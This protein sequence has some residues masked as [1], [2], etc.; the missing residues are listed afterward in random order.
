[1]AR[2][3]APGRGT[4][5]AEVAILELAPA[6]WRATNSPGRE[7]LRMHPMLTIASSIWLVPQTA[8]DAP[9]RAFA[10]RSALTGRR[11]SGRSGL[12]AF[13]SPGRVRIGYEPGMAELD[14]RDLRGVAPSASGG[15][16]GMRARATHGMCIAWARCA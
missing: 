12:V 5:A 15:R 11:D 14:V 3:T 9:V 13:A 2:R 16:L 4:A 10:S 1:M 6:A 7:A 8:P